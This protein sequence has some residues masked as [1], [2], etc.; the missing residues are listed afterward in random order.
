MRNGLDSYPASYPRVGMVLSR[1]QVQSGFD[2][3]FTPELLSSRRR[4]KARRT[5]PYTVET[6]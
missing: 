3:E 5:P 1:Y 6:Q 4:R 2:N